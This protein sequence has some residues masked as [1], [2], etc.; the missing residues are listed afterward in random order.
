[1]ANIKNLK[2]KYE[3][4]CKKNKLSKG[5]EGDEDDNGEEKTQV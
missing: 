1:M 5:G 3:T 4:L 2:V